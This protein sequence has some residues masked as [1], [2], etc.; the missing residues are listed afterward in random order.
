MK[1]DKIYNWKEDK[2]SYLVYGIFIGA[3]IAGTI[4]TII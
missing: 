2:R 4:L 3:V 1:D